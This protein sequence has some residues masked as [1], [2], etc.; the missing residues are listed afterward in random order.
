LFNPFGVAVDA[1]GNVYI[2]D[3][4]NSAI[5]KVSGGIITT[6]PGTLKDPRAVA[7]GGANVY[8]ADRS[9]NLITKLAAGAVTAVVGNG[10]PYEGDG[11]L[12]TNAAL[13]PPGDVAIDRSGNLF[14]PESDACVVRKIAAGTGILSTVAGTGICGYNGDNISATSAQLNA[15]TRVALD[16]AGSLYISDNNNSRIRKVSGGIITTVA[17]NGT[18]GYNGDNISATSAELNSP[19]GLAVDSSGNLFIADSANNRVRKVSGGII[20][21]VA[22]N[23]IAG[24]NGDSISAASA[25][26]FEPFGVALDGT[27]NL[28]IADAV[29]SRIRTVSGGII[30][31]VAGNG[32]PGY[33]GD[34]IIAT[35]AE[36]DAAIALAVDGNGNLYIADTHNSRIRKVAGGVITTIAGNGTAGFSGD[37]GSATGAEI[38]SANVSGGG[39]A[40]DS[41]GNVYVADPQNNRIRKLTP[42][43][44]AVT[45][46]SLVTSPNPSL[47]GQ[48]V[49]LTAFVSPAPATGSITFQDGSASL[50]T[51]TLNGGTAV[52]TLSTLSLGN[53]SLTAVYSG[54]GSYGASGSGTLT[55]TVT[56]TSYTVSGQVNVSGI[57]QAGVTVNVNG[58]Q[59][60]STTTNAAGFYSVSLPAIGIYTIAP[61]APGLT[62]SPVNQT[63]SLGG[64]QTANFIGF[65]QSG[66]EFYPIT[67]CRVV[68]TRVSSFASGFGPPTMGSG[69]ARSF[70]I[71]SGPCPIAANAAAYSFNVTVVPKGYLGYLSIWPTRRSR[72]SQR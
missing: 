38:N 72:W 41:N 56:G 42:H 49:T 10:L 54:D 39:L 32:T 30:T 33:N 35:A 7:A 58:S 4:G 40:L 46:T 61:A 29:N 3:T 14:I 11:G 6:L 36:F 2:A 23:G 18:A 60:I 48:N 71:L 21:T 37:G 53:H 26:L 69:T 55:Q 67:P 47:S 43:T 62:F 20:T 63:F 28:Y 57:A 12:A 64:N 44:A 66:L 34:S 13:S 52:L 59:T 50:G 65:G 25:E 24:Y 8:V 51:V 9:T 1:A 16:S 68:D 19:L 27:G 70:P 17:G 15:P 22:G 31:T 45:T 5:R